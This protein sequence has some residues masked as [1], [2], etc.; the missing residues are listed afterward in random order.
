MTYGVTTWA[1]VLPATTPSRTSKAE[2]V[3][4]GPPAG[5]VV[6]ATEAATEPVSSTKGAMSPSSKGRKD[7]VTAAS[8]PGDTLEVTPSRLSVPVIV[9]PIA[10]PSVH[11]SPRRRSSVAVT[12]YLLK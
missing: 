10:P 3:D 2:S 7:A 4:D 11:R 9:E 5:A 1:M 12:A 8:G 6:H